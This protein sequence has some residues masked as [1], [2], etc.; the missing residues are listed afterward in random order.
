MQYVTPNEDVVCT[1]GAT[2]QMGQSGRF[3]KRSKSGHQFPPAIKS[4][5]TD[6]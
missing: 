4:L 6:N 5:G 1:S 2:S 3:H